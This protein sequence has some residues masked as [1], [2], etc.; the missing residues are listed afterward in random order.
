MLHANASVNRY[1]Y[2]IIGVRPQ[3]SPI[4]KKKSNVAFSSLSWVNSSKLLTVVWNLERI[5]ITHQWQEFIG[6]LNFCCVQFL[7]AASHFPQLSQWSM[8]VSSHFS[9]PPPHSEQTA[10]VSQTLHVSAC[11]SAPCSLHIQTHIQWVV[12]QWH[13]VR[14]LSDGCSGKTDLPAQ[15]DLKG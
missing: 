6:S 13:V 12:G 3:L 8:S 4:L 11:L 9:K 1:T 15:D 5:S 14:H 7:R 10:L 2:W